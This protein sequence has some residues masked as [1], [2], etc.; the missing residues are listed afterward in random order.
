MA[1]GWGIQPPGRGP[2]GMRA[3]QP[4]PSQSDDIHAIRERFCGPK[5]F[6]IQTFNLTANQAIRFDLTGT[7]V[8]AIIVT[9]ASGQASFYFGDYTSGGGATAVTPHLV[10]VVGTSLEFALPPAIDYIIT[11]QEALG[12]T[13]SGTVIFLYQ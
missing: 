7:P 12:S 5:T 13:T 3:D 4:P 6:S 2:R 10:G 8:N 11:V 9:T 1:I